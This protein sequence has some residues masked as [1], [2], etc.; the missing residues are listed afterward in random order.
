MSTDA[1]ALLRPRDFQ[2]L[3]PFLDLDEDSEESDGLYADLLA[4]GAVLVHT[5]QPYEAFAA[6]PRVGRAWLAQFG[7]SL[8]LVHDD[9]RG[10]LFFPDD[11]E[12]DATSYAAVVEA[13]EEGGVWI[14]PGAP[15]EPGE[16]G[17]LLE[18]LAASLQFG[19]SPH[20]LATAV[21]AMQKSVFDALGLG[22]LG[23]DDDDDEVGLVVLLRSAASVAAKLDLDGFALGDVAALQDG[24]A[25]VS[26][27]YTPLAHD[28]VALRLAEDL[29]A[30]TAGP[31]DPR[32]VLACSTSDLDALAEARTYDEAL[33]ALGDRA[34]F[35]DLAAARAL[36]EAEK[37]RL[38][39]LGE[40]G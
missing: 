21:S 12:P 2:A 1:I 39:S 23:G 37:A 25:V 29:P 22:A 4:D 40:E 6:D 18:K 28:L 33:Q 38:R 3:A 34:V 32:G 13:I 15:A 26:T 24:T 31:V 20:D 10:V 35:L 19:A 14:A 5:F 16:P 17:H 11:L 36:P 30:L 8:P 9:P 7:E 27:V